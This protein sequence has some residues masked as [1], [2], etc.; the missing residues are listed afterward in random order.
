MQLPAFQRAQPSA[1]P[2]MSE[3]AP[4]FPTTGCSPTGFTAHVRARKQ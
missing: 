2:T 1:C 4:L 3:P